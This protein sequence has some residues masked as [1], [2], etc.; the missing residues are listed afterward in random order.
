MRCV[1]PHGSAAVNQNSVM[2]LD[3]SR[4]HG[5]RVAGSCFQHPQAHRRTWYSDASGVAKEI[6]RVLVDGH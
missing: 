3:F 4:S 5:I 6:D 2:F 1:G